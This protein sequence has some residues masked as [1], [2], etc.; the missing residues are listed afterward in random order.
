[1]Q[2]NFFTEINAYLQHKDHSLAVRR[3]LDLALDTRSEPHLRAAIDWSREYRILINNQVAAGL[4]ES[5]YEKG[6][7]LLK[8]ISSSYHPTTTNNESLVE[9]KDI[10][11]KYLHGNFEM[12]P[13]SLQVKSGEIIGIVGENGNGKTTLL[14]CL[15]GQLALD[16]GSIHYNLLKNFQH[17]LYHLSILIVLSN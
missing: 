5:F 9:A 2:Q 4:P 6:Q 12:K 15:A 3:M 1:M 10:A 7:Q 13:A 14:R 8:E 17:I 11:K 16:S